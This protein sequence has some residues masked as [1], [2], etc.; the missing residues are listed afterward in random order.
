METLTSGRERRDLY[1]KIKRL[2][3]VNKL[4]GRLPNEEEEKKLIQEYMEYFVDWFEKYRKRHNLT[5]RDLAEAMGLFHNKLHAYFDKDKND[6]KLS[7]L[8]KLCRRLGLTVNI[9]IEE[10]N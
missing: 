4:G 9:T 3:M 6:I 10:N 1:K 2:E 5:K 8:L 7:T